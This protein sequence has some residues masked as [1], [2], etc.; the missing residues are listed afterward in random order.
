MPAW[1]VPES[2]YALFECHVLTTPRKYIHQRK[3]EC[4][5]A[6]LAD[7]TCNVANVTELALDYGFLHLRRFSQSYRQQ[8]SELPSTTLKRRCCRSDSSQDHCAVAN[9]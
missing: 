7:P 3:L 6:C 2:L 4:A 8:V 5:H 1:R 9:G